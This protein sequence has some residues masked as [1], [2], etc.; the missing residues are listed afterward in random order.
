MSS[1]TY[2]DIWKSMSAIDVSE[3]TQSRAVGRQTRSGIPW[4]DCMANLQSHY[5]DFEYEFYPITLYPD[6]SA[7]V[8]CK[9]SIG[10]VSRVVFLPVMDHKFNA[11]VAGPESSPSSRDINDARW[12]AFVKCT[13]ILT[14]LGFNLFRAGEGK[15]A[16]PI[17]REEVKARREKKTL[18]TKLTQLSEVLTECEL[19]RDPDYPYGKKVKVKDIKLRKQVLK[20]GGPLLRVNKAIAFLTKELNEI[21]ES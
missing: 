6:G 18:A 2:A 20:A 3:W 21:K 9:V 14:G 10:E 8:G 13:A 1:P 5:P 17:V 4:S 12:R 11:I 7:E 19:T 16:E 15:P